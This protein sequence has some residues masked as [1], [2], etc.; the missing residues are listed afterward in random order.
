VRLHGAVHDSGVGIPPDRLDRL[1]RS[2][3]QVDASTT[4][5]Y[6]GTGLGLAICKR[7]VELMSGRIWVES[8]PGKGSSFHFEL[9]LTAVRG[10][11]AAVPSAPELAG[12]RLLIVEDNPVSARVLCQQGV[13]WGLVPRA[14]TS[15]A[16]A[17][18]ALAHGE[19]FD[20]AL[21]DLDLPEGGQRVASALR[22]TPGG[23]DLAIVLMAWPGATRPSDEAAGFGFLAKPVKPRAWLDLLRHMLQGRIRAA[24]EVSTEELLADEHP[25]AILLAEDNPV[26]RRVA[27]L[28]LRRFG[29]EVDVAGNGR[30]AVEAAG[31]KTYDLVL[32][33][34][35]MPEMDGLQATREIIRRT[36]GAPR[37]RIV[38][39]TAN[40][41]TGDRA[42]C[43]AAGMDDFL[44][45]PVR[46]ADL[47]NVLVGVPRR[48]AALAV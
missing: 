41:S 1:F 15:G 14:V 42:D 17:V 19:R 6:G 40:A 33:D 31:K 8:T 10:A 32:M 20:A 28:M 18:S 39:M 24:A 47:R 26:N 43:L 37:P 35:Q 38:A 36:A 3:S 16:E 48:H 23:S 9:E 11:E 44:A 12:R 13:A 22:A 7:L 34:V 5:Q 25:L 4:R 29:Y 30:E 45:K 2:F 46:A 27:T 21:I